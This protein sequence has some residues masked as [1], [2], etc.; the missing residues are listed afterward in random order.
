M[1]GSQ[2][3]PFALVSPVPIPGAVP[4][5]VLSV[6]PMIPPTAVACSAMDGQ[7]ALGPQVLSTI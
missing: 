3:L 6:L 1:A 7:A 2:P 4:R 5:L